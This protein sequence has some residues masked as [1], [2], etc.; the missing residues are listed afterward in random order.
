MTYFGCDTTAE[1]ATCTCRFCYDKNML[2]KYH[3]QYCNKANSELN[4]RIA[5]KKKELIIIKSVLDPKF[6]SKTIDIAVMGCG[7]LRF[8]A[9]HNKI[10]SEVFDKPVIIK[11]FDITTAHLIGQSNIYE[12]DCT[13][14]LPLGPYD[15]TFAHVLL[16]FIEKTKQWNVVLNSYKALKSNGIAIHILDPKDYENNLVDLSC[17]ENSLLENKIEYRKLT[18]DIGI[19]LVLKN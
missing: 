12:H 3:L 8:I 2:D 10:F 13:L 1:E 17:I 4:K 7:D 18:L 11:T 16:R 5:E 19:A 14:P 6:D 9:G 15:I